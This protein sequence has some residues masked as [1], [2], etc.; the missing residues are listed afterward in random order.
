MGFP[1]W[2]GGGGRIFLA[3]GV[4]GNLP[5]KGIEERA[6]WESRFALIWIIQRGAPF[7]IW[8]GLTS[9]DAQHVF[10]LCLLPQQPKAS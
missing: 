4:S 7:S 9:R 5:F 2:G 3:S 1:M 8:I 10:V 6:K